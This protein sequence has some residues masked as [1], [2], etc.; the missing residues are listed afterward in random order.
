MSV[1]YLEDVV[2]I[3]GNKYLAI[4]IAGL[5]ARQLN[6]KEVP[7]FTRKSASEAIEEFIKGKIEYNQLDSDPENLDDP[8]DVKEKDILK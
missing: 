3:V 8:F 4:H 2:K 7:L 1:V 5:R 6:K